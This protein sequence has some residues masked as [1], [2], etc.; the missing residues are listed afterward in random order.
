MQN[1]GLTPDNLEGIAKHAYDAIQHH[2]V[3]VAKSALYGN[4]IEEQTRYAQSEIISLLETH[5]VLIPV[6]KID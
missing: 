5:G 4:D 3:D 1:Y 6:K 2:A